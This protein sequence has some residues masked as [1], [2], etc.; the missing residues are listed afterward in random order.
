MVAFFVFFLIYQRQLALKSVL[1]IVKWDCNG[2]LK[3]ADNSK[4]FIQIIVDDI[5]EADFSSKLLY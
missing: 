3:A 5:L 4:S 1:K 2:N